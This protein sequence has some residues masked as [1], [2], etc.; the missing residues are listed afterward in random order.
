MI[1]QVSFSFIA[2]AFL[3]TF[4]CHAGEPVFDGHWWNSANYDRQIGF[5]S[6][7]SDCYQYELR[8]PRRGSR[9]VYQKRILIETYYRKQENLNKSVKVAIESVAKDA[10]RM[11]EYPAE[12]GSPHLEKHGY[13]DGLWWKSSDPN[14]AQLGFVEG[15]IS[16]LPGGGNAFPRKAEHY[17]AK[18]TEW[19]NRQD[20]PEAEYEK[21]VEVLVRVTSQPKPASSK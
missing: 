1:M 10:Q 3:S 9:S 12:G 15:Y 20:D 17:V 8:L 14:G 18:I 16:C 21:I 19:Y 7:E 11:S 2:L 13:Y 6:G 5:L 4:L